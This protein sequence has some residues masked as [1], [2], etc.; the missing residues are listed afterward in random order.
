MLAALASTAAI[1]QSSYRA[2]E[3]SDAVEAWVRLKG[4]SSGAITYEWVSGAAWGLPDGALAKPLFKFES[5]TVRKF[6]RLDGGPSRYVERSFSCRL[7]RDFATGTFS[8]RVDNPFTSRSVVLKPGCNP[9]PA[10]R[11]TPELVA[12]EKDIGFRSSAL[13][14][15]M[16]L[17]RLDLGDRVAMRRD[18]Q[19]EF[20]SRAGEL[21]REASLDSFVVD[22]AALAD[23]KITSLPAEYQWTSVTQ[24]MPEL[25]MTAVPGRMLWSIHG[26]KFAR[27]G[28]LPA[29]FREA[30]ERLSP[31][32]LSRT[33]D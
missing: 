30:L 14:A 17:E 29:D 26:R 5:V 13:G 27:P 15:P 18:A 21:R 32:V 22:A 4:D 20:T 25:G 28:D 11:Y 16:R 1:A 7:Y 12:L 10:V 33:P 9:G 6:T 23:R 24:W 8:D 31:G 19:S 2:L 3:P